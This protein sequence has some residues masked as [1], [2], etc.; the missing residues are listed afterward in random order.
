MDP[1]MTALVTLLSGPLVP[2]L[3][4]GAAYGGID[5]GIGTGA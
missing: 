4:A 5:S 2:I 3:A 1:D